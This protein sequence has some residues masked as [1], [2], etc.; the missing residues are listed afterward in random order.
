MGVKKNRV[1]LSRKQQK[2]IKNLSRKG[3]VS[4]R[5]VN[6][7]RVL[8]LSDEARAS[9][10]KTDVEIAENLDISVATVA[11]TR[12]RF[13]QEGL[14]E[15]LNEK[16]R[17]G[18]PMGISAQTRAK[19]TALACTKAPA[20][21]SDWTLRLL[22]D[23][24]VEL[25]Y[26]DSISYQSV[27]NILTK[28]ELKPHLKIQWCI[29][30]LS[31]L[32]IWQMEHILDLYAQPYDPKWPLWCFDERPCQLLGDTLVPIPMK[33]GKKWRYDHHYERQGVC[34]I[35]IAFQPHTGQRV[36]QVTQRRTAKEYAQFMIDLKRIH[37]PQ[38]EGLQIVQ[39]N[40]NTHQPSSFY[41][42]LPPAEALAMAKLF[43]MN[44]TPKNGSWL[45]MVEIEL[46]VIARQ[47]LNRRLDSMQ[48]LEQEVL[49]LVQQRNEASA[50]IN[51]QFTPE[52]AREKFKRF[53]PQV[54]QQ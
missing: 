8:L 6:R 54:A 34:N 48:L 23:K 53:Y 5:Q 49:T 11:R 38:A 51:W 36:V 33:P 43:E 42:I 20:G 41:T 35:L 10:G 19:V 47:C 4:A 17:S 31:P 16:P 25:E 21:R 14:Q 2:E 12:Q 9:G 18:R 28:N 52:L 45:N 29:G 15:A 30:E 32:Y 7:A 24:V 46:S 37:N 3:V 50:T 40:L 44:Y 27:R 39:D 13:C 26:I 22:A 1:R